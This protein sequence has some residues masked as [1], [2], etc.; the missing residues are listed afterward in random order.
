MIPDSI[1]AYSLQVN[2][3][4][5]SDF[6]PTAVDCLLRYAERYTSAAWVIS[7]SI[8]GSLDRAYYLGVA[9]RLKAWATALKQDK[10]KLQLLL[11]DSQAAAGRSHH[12]I[13]CDGF[14]LILP[15]GNP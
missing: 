15:E 7:P 13:P 9:I 8:S 4:P 12:R 11:P 2:N 5:Q 1:S 6:I 10:T 14:T 3:G